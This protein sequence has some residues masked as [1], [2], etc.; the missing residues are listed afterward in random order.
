[1][2]CLQVFK[3]EDSDYWHPA[4][5]PQQ[6]KQ[7]PA[8]RPGRRMQQTVVV[9]PPRVEAFEGGRG[10][11]CCCDTLCCSCRHCQG[12]PSLRLPP[13]APAPAPVLTPPL[14]CPL[15]LLSHLCCAE[16]QRTPAAEGGPIAAF[17]VS[18]GRNISQTGVKVEVGK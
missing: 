9:L 15:P 11:G 14:L 2:P 16:R 13:P 18:Q 1:M 3:A 8:R 7:R 17:N 10:D 12:H 6:Q 4:N 5:P